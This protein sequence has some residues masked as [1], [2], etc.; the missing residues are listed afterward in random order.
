MN[1][2]VLWIKKNVRNN[3]V[4][5]PPPSPAPHPFFLNLSWVDTIDNLYS[6]W[7]SLFMRGNDKRA[8]SWQNQ[9]NGVRP[10]KTQIRVW[11]ESSLSAIRKLG[12]LATHWAHS[13][14]WPDWVDA[15]SDLRL[16]GF[17]GCTCHF[18]GFV[19][20]RL[21]C[22]TLPL[23]PPPPGWAKLCPK[24]KT[25]RTVQSPKKVKITTL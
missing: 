15:Q 16:C 21:K 24:R 20:R 11:W 6:V 4:A 14:D 22:D 9:Q 25:R 2:I 13:E 23:P 3:F 7:L 5:S 18:V 17:A 12:S 10:A 8:D 19:R 1:L